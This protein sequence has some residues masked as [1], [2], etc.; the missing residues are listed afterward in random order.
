MEPTLED[1]KMGIQQIKNNKAT[2]CDNIPAE[3][4]KYAGERFERELHELI[5]QIWNKA[6]MPEEWGTA[7]VKL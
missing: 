6:S 5:I 1:I 3:F 4:I 7:A 2:G